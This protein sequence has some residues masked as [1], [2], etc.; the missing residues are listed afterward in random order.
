MPY[1]YLIDPEIRSKLK[2]NIENSIILIDEAHNIVRTA[3]QV[4]SHKITEDVVKSAIE[5][6]QKLKK[7]TL[8]EEHK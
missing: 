6:L 5:V 8:K 7:N 4:Y 1:N 3:E 2:V